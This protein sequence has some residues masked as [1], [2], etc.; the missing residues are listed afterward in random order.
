MS[1]DWEVRLGWCTGQGMLTQAF[2][3]WARNES[4]LRQKREE[5]VCWHHSGFL[6][7]VDSGISGGHYQRLAVTCLPRGEEV[8]RELSVQQS[9]WL[10]EV[11][12]ARTRLRDWIWRE[13]GSCEHLHLVLHSWCIFSHCLVGFGDWDNRLY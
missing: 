10:Q 11:F 8:R 4:D 7:G 5:T 12:C 1:Q 2:F 3:C 13:I 9:I 6:R